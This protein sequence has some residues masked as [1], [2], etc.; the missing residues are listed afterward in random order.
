MTRVTKRK[1]RTRRV[2]VRLSIASLPQAFAP[3]LAPMKTFIKHPDFVI[4][5]HDN[6]DELSAKVL[7]KSHNGKGF[8]VA[9]STHNSTH[10]LGIEPSK[11]G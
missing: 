7:V 2:K 9:Q 3:L 1:T 10:S 8:C 4:P 11:L 6:P 5:N